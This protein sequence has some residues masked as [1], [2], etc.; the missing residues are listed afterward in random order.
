V[1]T[2]ELHWY[3]AGLADGA[4]HQGMWLAGGG[5]VRSLCGI[6]FVPLPIGWPARRGPLPS[7][8]PDPQQICRQCRGRVR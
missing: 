3:V 7:Y 5:S 4:T 8:P 1:S 2:P 6:E